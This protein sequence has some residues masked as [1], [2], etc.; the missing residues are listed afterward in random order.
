MV[1]AL[2]IFGACAPPNA[3]TPY[4]ATRPPAGEPKKA[5]PEVA[6]AP[7]EPLGVARYFDREVDLEPFLAGF[8]YTDFHPDLEHGRL[9]YVDKSDHYR[10]RELPI[11]ADGRWD[12][13][14]GEPVS[15]VDWSARSLWDLHWNPPT[16]KL[17]LHADAKNDEQMNLWTLDPETGE[18]T[19]VTS[20]DYVYSM[21][22]S[23]DERTVAYLPRAGK[24][25]PFHTCLRVRDVE[26]GNEREVVCDTPSLSFTWTEL[27]FSAD[28]GELYFTAQQDGDRNRLQLVRVNLKDAAPKVE[29][30]A[31]TKKPRSSIELLEGWGPDGRLLL[32][33]NEDGYGNLWALEPG[34]RKLSQL[35]R[36]IEDVTSAE[37]VGDEVIAVH[38]TP[39][40]ST[41]VRLDAKT[42]AERASTPLPGTADV[43]DAH[44]DRALVTQAAPD[45]VHEELVVDLSKP[46]LSLRPVVAL[47]ED[48]EREIVAC[49]AT[50]VKIPTFDRDKATKKPRMLHAFLLEPRRPP[51]HDSRRLALVTAFYGGENRYSTFDHIMCAAGLT[52]VSPAVRGS[53]GF[54]RE[55]QALNDKDLGGDEI[56]DL[57]WV[58][59]WLQERTGL[60][61]SRIGVYGG[62]HGGYATM[63]ALT[64]DPATNGRNDAYAFGFGM[65]HAGFSDIA[66]FYEATNIPDWVVLESGD[67]SVAR[68]LARMKD[69]SPLSHVERLNAPLLLTHG[70]ADWRVPVEESRR[71]A[72]AAKA[73]GRPVQYVE[74]EGQGHHI[75]G[76]DLQVQ[77]YQTRFDFLAAV[78]EALTESET[79]SLGGENASP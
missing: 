46:G 12:L 68:D 31:P 51:S 73:Q 72:E 26:T 33:S 67:P 2:G 49:K 74:F 21:G 60:P 39:A 52:V 59:R 53:S 30:L 1:V 45:I 42:G 25:A 76:L 17:W 14:A 44:G 8:P 43:S 34:R 11:P 66:S 13:G 63:R 62:S 47:D 70:S 18:L 29:V 58:G 48:L 71:F 5:E 55:F 69:R 32:L 23:E 27:R 10:L 77:L 36:Y 41:L 6:P 4:P 61:A 19:A 15:E 38:R 22:F 37:L 75:E 54:G 40:G 65:A 24:K 28:G 7:A 57:F 64:F 79:R 16:G 56:V 78:A 9:W 3:A 35:T 20:H 50:A